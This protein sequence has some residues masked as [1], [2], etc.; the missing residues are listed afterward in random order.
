MVVKLTIAGVHCSIL[1]RAFDV[2]KKHQLKLNLEKRL[3]EA[4]LEKCQVVIDMRSPRN[5]KELKDNGI[6]M[7]PILVSQKSPFPFFIA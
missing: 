4:D 1:Q 6:V 3:F 2:L 5:I 7:L